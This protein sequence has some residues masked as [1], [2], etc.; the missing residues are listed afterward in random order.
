MLAAAYKYLSS[1]PIYRA[2][3]SIFGAT[4]A[5]AVLLSDHV[6]VKPNDFVID[7]GCGPGDIL[8][9]LPHV[10][11]VGFDPEHSYVE[12]ARRRYGGRAEFRH[13]SVEQAD[14]Q[15]FTGAADIVMANGVLHHLPDEGAQRL[16]A[17]AASVLKPMGR[18]VT[19]DPVIHPGQGAIRRF[20]VMQDR[21]RFVRSQEQYRALA[22]GFFA[23]I[24]A[25][26]RHDLL[27]LPYSHLILTCQSPQ[28]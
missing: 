17:I 3:Q 15:E 18:C 12:A 19:I 14:V 20:A 7:I 16:F 1:A 10:H 13:A 6:R 21:G 9:H 5:R 22:A 25:T 26:V 28:K 24:N 8:E 11:Y 4:R 27:R 23:D 2:L